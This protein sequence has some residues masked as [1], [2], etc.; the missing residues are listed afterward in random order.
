M[1]HI[2]LFLTVAV[3]LSAAAQPRHNHNSLSSQEVYGGFPQTPSLPPTP[4]PLGPAP[5]QTYNA[6]TCL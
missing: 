2:L 5:M 4:V 6:A 3:L 1:V